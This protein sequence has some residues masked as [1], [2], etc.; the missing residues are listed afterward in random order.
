MST[1]RNPARDSK[2]KL[3]R[4]IIFT[5]ALAMLSG[6]GYEV[7]P[8]APAA[9]QQPPPSVPPPSA[10]QGGTVA[11]SPRYAALGQGASL[12]FN[13]T[14]TSGA[15]VVWLVNGV[16][17]GN[18][19]S[20]TVDANGKYTAPAV[21]TSSENITVTAEL[22][23]SSQTNFANSVVSLIQP[24][25]ITDTLNPQV[26]IYSIYLPAPGNVH[27]DFGPGSPSGF[28]TWSQPTS[29]PTGGMVSI[30]VAGMRAQTAYLMQAQVTLND[31]ATFTDTLQTFTPG[32][33]PAT[34]TVDA[35]AQ[36]GG[37]PQPGIE[38]FDTTRPV[39]A[40]RVFATDLAGN[41]IW[42]YAYSGSPL[43]IVQPIK[44]LSNGHF[45]VQISYASSTSLHQ[46]LPPNTLD[47]VRE[48]DL[49]GNTIRSLT[50]QN[51][52]AALAAKGYTLDLG[53]FHHD[54][55]PLPNG[56][57]VLLCSV[58]QTF[59]RL[60]GFVRPI[61]V[62]GDLLVDVDQNFNP[63]WVW[64]SFDHL[65]VNRHPYL[66]PDWTHSNALLYSVDDH[67]LLLSV[68]H[69]NWILK[70][71]FND[72]NGTGNILWRLGE[73]GDFQLNGGSDPIDWFYAQHGPGY[74]SPNTTGIFTLGVMDN[75]DD[76]IFPAGTTCGAL[77]A[78][79]CLYSAADVLQVDESHMVATLISRYAPASI[80][81]FYGGNVDSLANGDYEV[82]F[83]SA[84]PGALVQELNSNTQQIVWQ[85]T[86]PGT[87]QYR[88]FRLPSLY[89]GV[90]W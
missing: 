12:Q 40:A 1:N 68:R 60:T 87:D 43:D 79:P 5:L 54:V 10:T 17:G 46:Q 69:Q 36:N 3:P 32:T 50:M 6:C 51:L 89:P 49:A 22:P 58:T 21:L 74:F 78:P 28:E 47:E 42:T 57:L 75:G 20:G 80:Y 86:T 9:P 88:A 38:M 19:T 2:R 73:G 23:G 67:N 35:S 64:N 48:I 53:S 62:L 8:L 72:A 81:S 76:R 39:E 90:Q 66:F 70:I 59:P 85:A 41:V 63:D 82:D 16:A 27:I 7:K 33:P 71:D 77:N 52:A 26:V 65:D 31:G 61:K 4:A 30:F 34:A 13:A 56:H 18:S 55:L 29:A 37:T 24:G 83:C 15:S 45:L 84:S 44:F 14:V 25:V 11:L